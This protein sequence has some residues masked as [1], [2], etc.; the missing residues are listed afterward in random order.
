[1]GAS[2]A[3]LFPGE[4]SDLG[5][6]TIDGGVVRRHGGVDGRNDEVYVDI[7]HEDCSMVR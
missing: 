5:E 4:T 7:Y 6:G 3:P 1:V 2:L